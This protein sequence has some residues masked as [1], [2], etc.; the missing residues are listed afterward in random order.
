MKIRA[1][2]RPWFDMLD[3]IH[4]PGEATQAEL[5]KVLAEAFAETLSMVHV[6]TGSLKGS[7]RVRMSSE[8]GQWSG[9]ISYGGASPGFPHDPVN[10]AEYEFGRGGDHDALRNVDLFYDDFRNAMYASLNA[11]QQA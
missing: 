9:S 11:R 6:I 4:G 10:Y 1:D 5:D 7:G 2:M 8:E 3:A